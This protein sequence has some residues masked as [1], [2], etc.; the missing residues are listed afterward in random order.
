MLSEGQGH[1]A[2]E[3]ID[4]VIAQ[5]DVLVGVV[6]ESHNVQNPPDIGL[7]E[8]KESGPIDSRAPSIHANDLICPLYAASQPPST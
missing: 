3:N 2:V 8:S 4:R 5:I 7:R 1:H 6:Q